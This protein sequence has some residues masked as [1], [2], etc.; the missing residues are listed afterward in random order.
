MSRALELAK[1]GAGSVSPNPMVGCVVVKDNEI[2]GEGWHQKFGGAHAEVEALRSVKNR[3]EIPGST[4]YVSLEPCAHFGKTPPCTNL[5]INEK[6]GKVV[7]GCQ[8]P[9]PAVNGKG[10]R[11]LEDSGIT[12]EISKLS[13]QALELNRRFFTSHLKHRPYII[14]KWAQTTDGFVAR[15]DYTSKWI[16][17]ELSRQWVHRWRSE[18]DAVVIG[19]TTAEKDNASLTVREWTGRNPVRVMLLNNGQ[20]NPKWN[21]FDQS[22]TTLCYCAGQKIEIP[23][24]ETITCKENFISSILTDLNSRGIISLIVEGGAKTFKSF[25]DLGLWDEARVFTSPVSF[26]EGIAAPKI[27]GVKVSKI[28]SGPDQLIIIRHPESFFSNGQA[29]E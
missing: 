22:A 19:R 21:I 9:N 1:R 17:S 2:I 27:D 25:I 20:V 26:G 6:V 5:L 3:S 8:D 28:N 7:I 15:T 18:E 16:S 11:Q 23:G 10:I 14:L 24:C 4:V 12:V 29:M 13:S